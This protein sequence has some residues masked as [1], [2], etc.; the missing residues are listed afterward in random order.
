MTTMSA[1]LLSAALQRQASVLD[2][3]YFG[4]VA[5]AKSASTVKSGPRPER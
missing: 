5:D 1:Q 2:K 4:G 3:K